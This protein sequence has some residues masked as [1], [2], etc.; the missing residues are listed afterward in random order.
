MFCH[1]S[2]TKNTMFLRN[3]FSSLSP[4]L[5]PSFSSFLPSCLPS[6]NKDSLTA[7]PVPG[8]GLGAGSLLEKQMGTA[9]LHRADSLAG[10]SDVK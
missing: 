8:S 7:H 5:P 3:Q 10:D 9:L 1:L 6:F 4:S 2:I